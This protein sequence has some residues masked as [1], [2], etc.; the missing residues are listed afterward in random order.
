MFAGYLGFDASTKQVATYAPS[1]AGANETLFSVFVLHGGRNVNLNS[2][3]FTLREATESPC[4]G[5]TL[6]Q[7]SQ[8][9]SFQED[10]EREVVRGR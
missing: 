4:Q 3:S 9:S 6:A 5:D 7:S 2:I 1:S 10:D 8:V